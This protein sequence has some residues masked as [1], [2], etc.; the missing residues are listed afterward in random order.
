MG[1][2]IVMGL[3]MVTMVGITLYLVGTLVR[4]IQNEKKTKMRLWNVS[5]E[6]L[7]QEVC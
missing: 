1:G 2:A 6:N 3:V 5:E 7:S 4:S